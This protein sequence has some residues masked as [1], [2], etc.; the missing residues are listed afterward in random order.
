MPPPCSPSHVLRVF[1]R[2]CIELIW[3]PIPAGGDAAPVDTGQDAVERIFC[4][5]MLRPA[6]RFFNLSKSLEYCLSAMQ[7]IRANTDPTT[8][9]LI[10]P[11]II[12]IIAHTEETLCKLRISTRNSH[13]GRQ[14]AD[15]RIRN[16]QLMSSFLV[17]THLA[18]GSVY[19]EFE[20]WI[21]AAVEF[22]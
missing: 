21:H 20:A 6:D 14:L 1:E 11:E 16:R 18:R 2:P 15:L 13:L 7:G 8:A 10:N 19:F 17:T 5:C 4:F 3:D 9:D 22:V 12:S